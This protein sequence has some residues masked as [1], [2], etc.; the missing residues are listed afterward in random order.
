MAGNFSKLGV[1]GYGWTMKGGTFHALLLVAVGCASPAR[2]P[3]IRGSPVPDR[4]RPATPVPTHDQ[5]STD[6]RTAALSQ[7]GAKSIAAEPSDEPADEAAEAPAAPLPRLTSVAIF[8]QIYP[9]P[10]LHYYGAP[11]GYLHPGSSVGLRNRDPVRGRP[12]CS[13]AWYAVEPRGWICNDNTTI[14]ETE[15]RRLGENAD[16]LVRGLQSVGSAAGPLPFG[17]ALSLGAPMYGRIPTAAEQA[18]NEN[19][20]GAPGG[21]LGPWARGHEGLASGGSTDAS[22]EVPWFLANGD[23]APTN[24]R[25]RDGRLIRK[26]APRGSMVSF[27]SAFEADGR[28][29]LVT[30]ELAIIPADRVRLYR[31]SSF[32]GVKL[33]DA[34]SLPLAWIRKSPRPKLRRA[35][36]GRI[37]PTAETWEVRTAVALTGGRVT[38]DDRVFLLT[39]EPDTFIDESDATVVERSQERPSGVG[40]DDKWIQIS[41]LKGTL[42]AYEGDRPVFTTLISPGRGGL[43]RVANTGNHEHVKHHTT[44]LGVFRIQYKDRYSVMSPDPEQ[45]KFFIS[46]VPYIQYFRGPFALHATFWHEDFGD[47]KSGGC[48]NLSPQDAERL[49]AWTDPQLPPSWQGVRSGGSNGPGT[50]VQIVP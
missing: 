20:Y 27:A 41:I 16:R 22:R 47:P 6:E 40:P 32:A 13:T 43:P 11:L 35:S 5:G 25:G 28:K 29:W 30:P 31:S 14:L 9:G 19:M 48:V 1:Q 15:R 44:P 36:D 23:S 10:G 24:V 12:D 2:A 17:Y 33:G 18:L 45:K 39:R 3:D 26:Y 37:V 49:F 7:A 34:I 21:P 38:Q 4:P 42:T 8:T 46:D 50:V